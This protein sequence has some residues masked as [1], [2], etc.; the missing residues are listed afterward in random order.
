[1]ENYKYITG[2]VLDD[3]N[4][5]LAFVW[6]SCMC[7]VCVYMAA[8]CRVWCRVA[9]LV[10]SRIMMPLSRVRKKEREVLFPVSGVKDF[11]VFNDILELV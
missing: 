7:S 8:T 6:R 11:C 5:S 4:V 2:Y 9:F 1:M 3:F 10:S